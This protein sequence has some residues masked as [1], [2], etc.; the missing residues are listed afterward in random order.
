MSCASACR[1]QWK[2]SACAP[3]EKQIHRI[4]SWAELQ[5]HSLASPLPSHPF[6]Q[7]PSCTAERQ[8]IFKGHMLVL[9]CWGRGDWRLTC[10]AVSFSLVPTAQW[11]AVLRMS[12]QKQDEY[13]GSELDDSC[14]ILKRSVRGRWCGPGSK[15]P[16][17]WLISSHEA[18]KECP[19]HPSTHLTA[20]ESRGGIFW[21]CAGRRAALAA[22]K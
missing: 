16:A 18:W 6:L 14:L 2:P 15:G 9:A 21:H 1:R 22:R 8:H 19:P 11:Q 20:S 13:L 10:G 12:P 7:V 17:P 4:A 5:H 3:K